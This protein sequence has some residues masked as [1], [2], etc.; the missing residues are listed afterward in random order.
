MSQEGKEAGGS[1]PDINKL[2][3]MVP[4]ASE[5]RKKETSIKEKRI[6]VQFDSSLDPSK[7]KIPTELAKMLGIKEGDAVEL[8]VAGKKKFTYTATLFESSDTNVVYAHPD[9][10]TRQGVANNSIATV[11]RAH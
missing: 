5:L 11:R 6:R 1:K 2:L 8:V 3:A 10:L 9:E 7:M 4:P